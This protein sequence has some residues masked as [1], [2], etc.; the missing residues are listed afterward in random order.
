MLR[1][2]LAVSLMTT[3]L[4]SC[5]KPPPVSAG[6]VMAELRPLAANCAEALADS[7]MHEAQRTCLRVIAAVEAVDD[8]SD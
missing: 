1:T 5:A 2:L 3:L 6:A 4:A 7:G 8:G